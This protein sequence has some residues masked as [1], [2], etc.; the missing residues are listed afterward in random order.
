VVVKPAV[1]AVKIDAVTEPLLPDPF[2][3][4]FWACAVVIGEFDGDSSVIM[5]L[6][7]LCSLSGLSLLFKPFLFCEK[8]D[9]D[10]DA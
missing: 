1:G 7:V 3:G 8:N 5:I 2:D 10:E 9:D 6:F 4:L